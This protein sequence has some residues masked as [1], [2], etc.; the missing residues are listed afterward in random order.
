VGGA[1]GVGLEYGFVP[2]WSVALEYNH[3]FL[4]SSTNNFATPGR[5]VFGQHP[6]KP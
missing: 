2:N 3:V 1:L 4:G 6:P 5:A